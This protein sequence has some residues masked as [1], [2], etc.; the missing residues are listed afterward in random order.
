MFLLP[1]LAPAP[2]IRPGRRLGEAMHLSNLADLADL[3]A[4]LGVIISL[5][6]VVLELRRNTHAIKQSNW[7]N[8]VDREQRIGSDIADPH[9]SDVIARGRQSYFALSPAD[10]LAFGRY[11][12]VLTTQIEAIILKSEEQENYD[13]AL[14]ETAF[15]YYFGFPGT[16]E[17]FA[18]YRRILWFP[19]YLIV[20]ID[21]AIAEGPVLTEPGPY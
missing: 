18:E 9:L 12:V 15:R 14:S 8:W 13:P 3:L 2:M 20:A 4:A 21:K 7:D 16:R 5:V 19:A 6:F 17:W 11:H 1:V 10:R